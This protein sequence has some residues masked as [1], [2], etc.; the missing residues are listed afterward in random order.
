MG[1]IPEVFECLLL[2]CAFNDNDTL[3]SFFFI[4]VCVCAFSSSTRNH[5]MNEVHAKWHYRF[6]ASISL[7]NDL[8]FFFSSSFCLSLSS[9][10]V[11]D[12]RFS[13]L[14]YCW[15]S[16]SPQII[17]ITESSWAFEHLS[18]SFPLFKTFHMCEFSEIFTERTQHLARRII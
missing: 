3:L 10:Q 18:I 11:S 8:F 2:L 16:N 7:Q 5:R 13:T 17:M 9:L 1:I 6:I 4:Y 15:S 12:E 14:I